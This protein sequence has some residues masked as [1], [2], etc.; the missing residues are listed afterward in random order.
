MS[1]AQSVR[2]PQRVGAW[3]DGQPRP[4]TG[5][6]LP[7]VNPALGRPVSVLT[8]SD[9]GQVEVAVGAARAAFERGPWPRWSVER[10]QAVLR[11][12][13]ARL[14]AHAEE[15]AW[16]E[17]QNTGIVLREL[18]QRHL[19]RAAAN[20]GFFA[21]YIGQS[22]E[23]VYR[24]T[25]GYVS[26]V[27]REPAGVAALISPWNAPV[28]LSSMQIASAIAF[29]ATCV[30]KPSEQSPLA[31]QR[32]VELMHEAGLPPGVVNVVNGRGPVTGQAL[33]AHPDV[34]RVCF[35]GGTETGRRIMEVAASHLA[36][37]TLELGG[38]SANIVFASADLER[39]LDGALLG[40]FSNNGQQ[41]L[42]GSR[43]LVQR[44]VFDD[45][46]ARFVERA[47]RLRI[48]DPMDAATELG[49][50]ASQ[51]QLQRVLRY[52]ELAREDGG[53]VLT[54]GAALP[55]L[56]PGFY[57]APTVVLALD[58]ACRVAQ[59][60]IFGP[61]ATLLPFDRVDDA[62]AIANASRYGLVSYVWS[63]HLPTVTAMTEGLRTGVVWVNTPM[64][65]ELRAPFGGFKD[66]GVGR[67][68]G[69]AC[70]AFFT[71]EKVVTWPTTPP[72]LRRLGA[73]P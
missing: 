56:G 39:A 6:E 2:L 16:L 70:E 30:I 46:A 55:S 63:D 34:R 10:R 14:L 23:H 62:L 58:N 61:F 9:A 73:G 67:Q 19:P 3:I 51:A 11:D 33:V 59:D 5:E 28:A 20:F 15:L 66:S 65:R 18:R 29:G 64:M 22:A 69:A 40:I 27:M 57:A 47:R 53:S 4:G 49:P 32:M 38:K 60:E 48:G 68:G 25:P 21:D 43:I 42:A 52:A 13:Q 54:G 24:Q 71:E 50:L 35:T 72:A 8:E 45:F 36:P 37:C 41:C 44:S 12:I 1:V 31:V 7:I 17:C 26:T